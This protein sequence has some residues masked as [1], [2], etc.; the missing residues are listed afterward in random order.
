MMRRHYSYEYAVEID[1]CSLCDLTWFEKDEL[2]ALQVLVERQT[3]PL[4]G[5]GTPWSD[6]PACRASGRQPRRHLNWSIAPNGGL[7]RLPRRSRAGR[8]GA[9]PARHGPMTR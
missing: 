6:R 8:F 7:A 3:W 2:E 5:S 4:D 1:Y 9:Y